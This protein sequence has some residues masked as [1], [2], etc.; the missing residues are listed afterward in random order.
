[1]ITSVAIAG[2][3]VLDI[4]KEGV[5]AAAVVV[6]LVSIV[7][8]FKAV[9]MP[10]LDRV[11]IIRTKDT[12]LAGR[13][14]EGLQSAERV[15]SDLAKTAAIQRET[16]EMMRKMSETILRSAAEQGAGHGKTDRCRSE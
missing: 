13:L 8:V 1:M 2:A 11:I 9:I 5:F 14:S 16:L 3:N 7:V 4:A 12:E 15:C 10:T 6:I